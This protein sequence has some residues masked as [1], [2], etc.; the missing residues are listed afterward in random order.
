MSSGHTN[1]G[2]HGDRV[3][4]TMAGRVVRD[5]EPESTEDTSQGCIVVCG[6]MMAL[7]RSSPPL[8]LRFPALEMRLDACDPLSPVPFPP[9][10]KKIRGTRCVMSPQN[11]SGQDVDLGC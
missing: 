9:W 2:P 4:T 3:D 1:Y 8:L 5:P 6:R 7:S 11:L 10:V